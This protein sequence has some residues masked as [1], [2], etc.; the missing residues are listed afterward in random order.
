MTGDPGDSGEAWA[1]QVAVRSLPSL[2]LADQFPKFAE[3]RAL[4]C[5]VSNVSQT[6]ASCS[7]ISDYPSGAPRHC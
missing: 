5:V 2:A 6:R 1:S 3:W 7:L 4:F